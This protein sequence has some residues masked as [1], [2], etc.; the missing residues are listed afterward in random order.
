MRYRSNTVFAWILI[1]LAVLGAAPSPVAALQATN[2]AS[3]SL[4]PYGF[5][6]IAYAIAWILVFGWVVSVWRRLSKL[7]ARLG[8]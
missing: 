3:Q 8:D 4:R 7:D 2:L 5:V 6:F 1:A